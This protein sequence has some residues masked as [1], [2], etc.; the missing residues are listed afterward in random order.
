[1]SS[2][3]VVKVSGAGIEFGRQGIYYAYL[4]VDSAL[5][6]R[7]RDDCI[8]IRLSLEGRCWIA[9]SAGA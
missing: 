8:N 6:L 2:P 9:L 1:M 5:N 4:L 7:R 3:L